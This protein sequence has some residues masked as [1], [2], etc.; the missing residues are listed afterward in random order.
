MLRLNQKKTVM[1]IAG[2]LLAIVCFVLW[3]LSRGETGMIYENFIMKLFNESG[4]LDLTVSTGAARL[5]SML[6]DLSI[7]NKYPLGAGFETYSQLWHSLLKIPLKDV[8]SC[9]GLTYSMATIG[10]VNTFYILGFYLW[11]L[12]K[13]FTDKYMKFAYILLFLNRFLKKFINPPYF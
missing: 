12:N 11:L 10:Y 8:A 6:A 3:D 2:I 7:A 9:V 4:D 5:Y 13:N 1:Y